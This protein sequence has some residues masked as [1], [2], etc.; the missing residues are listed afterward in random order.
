MRNLVSIQEI[1]DIQPIEGAD[2]IE[3]ATILGWK[4]V[5]KK[6]EFKIGD[7]CVYFEVDSFLPIEEKYEFLRG[8]SYKKHE[9]LGEG[10]RIRTQKLRGQISQGLVLSLSA[11]GLDENLEIG[12]DVTD[13]LHVQKWEALEH[14][15]DFGIIRKGLPDGIS[16]TDETR[17]QNIYDEMM[18]EFAGRRYYISTKIDGTSVTMYRKN[19]K[20]GV[21]SHDN[22]VLE[23]D[24][25][26][27]F[28]WDIAR[29]LDLEKKM[30]EKGY[31]NLAIQ[32]ELAGPKIQKNRLQLKE[33][34]WFVFTI[35]DLTTGK[36]LNLDNMLEIAKDLELDT[37]P[38]EETGDNLESV[39]PTL[40]S[41]LE[42]AK[43][44]Y[45]SG[46]NKEGI[47]IRPTEPVY[48]YTIGGSLSFKV[49]NNDFLLKE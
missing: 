34:E 2:R 48:S 11:L 37:V 6:D 3:V 5:I 20:F 17:I 43:G 16:K 31:D 32:G 10:F 4:L 28:L 9:Y 21:C 42:R 18:K 39:Y 13:I 44:K 33:F 30:I 8:S 15:S 47:V 40:D 49:L 36:R 35:K 23:D 1:R 29:K 19:E 24:N 45:K 46:Q 22:E 7:K 27:S 25:T 26:K 41:L 12:T 38:I 14:P